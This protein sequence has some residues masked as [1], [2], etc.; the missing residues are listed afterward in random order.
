[1]LWVLRDLNVARDLA[2]VGCNNGSEPSRKQLIRAR[3]RGFEAMKE[4]V[5]TRACRR[6]VLLEY[7]GE[8][9]GRC[10]GCDRC[11]LPALA[12]KKAQER[13]ASQRFKM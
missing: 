9:V 13:P 6:R 2:G 4:Y 5:T 1:M 11:G 7:L 8:K 3:R 10:S 12:A